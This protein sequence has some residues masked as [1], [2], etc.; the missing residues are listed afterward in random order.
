[1]KSLK[2]F[3]SIEFVRNIRAKRIT[4]KIKADGLR[5]S[6]PFHA[7]KSA[8]VDFILHKKAEILRRQKKIKSKKSKTI[9]SPDSNIQTLTFEIQ[10]IITQRDDLYFLLR[11]G[12]LRVEIPSEVDLLATETQKSCWKGISYFLRQEAKELLPNKVFQL[13]EQHGFKVAD[14]K[15]Q[16]SKTRWGSCSQDQ[17]INLSLYLMLLPE[18]LIDYVI[19]HEL[20]HTREM[21]HGDAFWRLM[22]QVTNNQSDRL[23]KELKNYEIPT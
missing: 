10:P 12:V 14:V 1:M 4:V 20:C 13:A 19:L 11:E 18:H 23:K 2:D 9:I 7:N 22:D 16:S 3:G 8:A 5:I 21:N 15:I 17:N 6:M